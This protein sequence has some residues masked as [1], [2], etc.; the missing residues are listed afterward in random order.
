MQT[1]RYLQTQL[2]GVVLATALIAGGAAHASTLFDL[3]ITDSGTNSPVMFDFGDVSP[4]FQFT[5][6]VIEVTFSNPGGSALALTAPTNGNL[7]TCPGTLASGSTCALVSGILTG[8]TPGVHNVELTDNFTLTFTEAN[9]TPVSD[10]ISID[11]TYTVTPLPATLQ[12]FAAGLGLVGFLA[13][14]RTR[15]SL[16][17]FRC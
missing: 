10:P 6:G 2:C 15:Q 1:K 7:G 17:G 14:R 13:K 5:D 3:D 11:A 8:G 9:G 4:T 16:G 12:L